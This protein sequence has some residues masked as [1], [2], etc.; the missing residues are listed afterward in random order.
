ML[1]D[2]IGSGDHLGDVGHE[3]SGGV[4]GADGFGDVVVLGSFVKHLGSVVLRGQ[5]RGQVDGNHLEQSLS[6]WEPVSHE[7][8]ELGLSAEILVVSYNQMSF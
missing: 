2:L 4:A 8:F 6:S 1:T 3:R 7:A 5:G